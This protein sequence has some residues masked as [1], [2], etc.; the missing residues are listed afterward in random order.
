[1]GNGGWLKDR[2]MDTDA[3]SEYLSRVQTFTSIKKA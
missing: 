2:F 3:G 1:M